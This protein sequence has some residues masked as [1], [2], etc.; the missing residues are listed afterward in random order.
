MIRDVVLLV[1][2][3]ASLDKWLD[4]GGEVDPLSD[5][6]HALSDAIAFTGLQSRATDA[7]PQI[8]FTASGEIHAGGSDELVTFAE[9]MRHTHVTA[10]TGSPVTPTPITGGPLEGTAVLKGS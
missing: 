7:N 1:F 9:F 4:R 8:E 10:G 3:S 6:R 5:R 2:C